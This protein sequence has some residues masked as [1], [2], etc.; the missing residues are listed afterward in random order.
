[1]RCWTIAVSKKDKILLY[2]CKSK[3]EQWKSN[4]VKKQNC[5]S[6]FR[7]KVFWDFFMSAVAIGFYSRE[8][9]LRDP[10]G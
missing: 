4:L 6:P 3:V 5:R 2:D 9:N 1:M 8:N 10:Y 7:K